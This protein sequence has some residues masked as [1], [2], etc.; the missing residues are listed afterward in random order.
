MRTR[1][2]LSAVLSVVLALSA[3]KFGR[4]PTDPGG[5]AVTRIL[6]TPDSVALDPLQGQQFLAK[7]ITA[8]GDTVAATVSWTA[9]AGTVSANGMD[10]ADASLNHGGATGAPP[11]SQVPRS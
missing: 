1:I 8:S 4:Q 11:G 6:V 10:T 7:G 3:C 5:R 2:L 9:S